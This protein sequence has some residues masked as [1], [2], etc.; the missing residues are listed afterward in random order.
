MQ[1]LFAAFCSS[2][3]RKEKIDEKPDI[4]YKDI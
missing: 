1:T 4:N 2:D 3:D